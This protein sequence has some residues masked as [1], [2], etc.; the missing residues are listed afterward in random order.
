[1]PK[2]LTALNFLQY[3]YIF[4]PL[5]A[6]KGFTTTEQKVFYNVEPLKLK[7][8]ISSLNS[9][10]KPHPSIA[11]VHAKVKLKLI[12]ALGVTFIPILFR[13]TSI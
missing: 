12:Q 11:S 6:Y 10:S 8:Q 3:S 7:V 4:T 1:M 5:R 9:M 2:N 13:K